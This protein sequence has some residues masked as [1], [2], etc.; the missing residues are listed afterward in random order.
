MINDE[1]YYAKQQ[2]EKSGYTQYD[3]DLASGRSK[4][5]SVP[6]EHRTHTGYFLA[7]NAL[8]E[9][10]FKDNTASEKQLF[11]K[12]VR[13]DIL[14]WEH[15]IQLD[16]KYSKDEI[17]ENH[18]FLKKLF[19]QCVADGYISDI[20]YYTKEQPEILHLTKCENDLEMGRIRM[21]DVPFE[22][23]T[24]LGYTLAKKALRYNV[25]GP[26]NLKEK[27]LFSELLAHDIMEWRKM[28]KGDSEYPEEE[29]EYRIHWLKDTL[30]S[31]F[32]EGYFGNKKNAR[33]FSDVINKKNLHKSLQY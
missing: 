30:Y 13:D 25:F 32:S 24:R 21:V 18:N 7:N 14:Q 6:F 31:C 16:S 12:T 22:Y 9:G 8:Q 1:E 33:E 20:T 2:P 29:L 15:E 4:I 10:V 17:V 28:K 27:R 19:S 3:E 26:D 23:R 5:Y 11:A